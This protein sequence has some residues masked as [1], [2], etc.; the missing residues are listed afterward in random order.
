M[1][2]DNTPNPEAYLRLCGEHGVNRFVEWWS[3]GRTGL[4]KEQPIFDWKQESDGNSGCARERQELRWWQ[5]IIRVYSR[6][7]KAV[8]VEW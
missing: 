4:K 3:F 6:V 7:E 8:K 1:M 2:K 5:T